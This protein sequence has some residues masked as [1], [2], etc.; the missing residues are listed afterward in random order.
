MTKEFLLMKDEYPQM[1]EL[2]QDIFNSLYKYNPTKLKDHEINYDY[3]LNANVMDAIMKSKQYKELRSLTRLDKLNSATGTKIL[4]T[5]AKDIIENIQE[6]SKKAMEAAQQ[7][8][9]TAKQLGGSGKSTKAQGG[10]QLTLTEA[11][12]RLRE[13]EKELKSKLMTPKEQRV[14]ARALTTVVSKTKESSDLITDWGLQQ[15]DS[16]TRV[17]YQ[18]Q[19]QL[20]K[21]LQE[22][23]KLRAIAAL[24]GRY[25]R[26]ILAQKHTKIKR[27]SD[28]LYDITLGNDL[29]KVIPSEAMKLKNPITRKVFIKQY[30]EKSLLQH[31]YEGKVKKHKGAIAIAIDESGSMDGDKEI[32]AKALALGLMEI[33][34]MQ[35]RNL[36]IV[37]FNA[38]DK[39]VLRVDTFL[40]TDPYDINKVI[41][42]ATYFASGSTRFSPA[43]DLCR[44]RINL[45]T[46]F[47]TADIILIT[48]GSSAVLP[49]WA[50][51]FNTWK[52][53]KKVNTYGV[54]ID[55][56]Y[57]T[58]T[59]IKDFIDDITRMSSFTSKEKDQFMFK[60]MNNL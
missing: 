10:E 24:M 37:H 11:I 15:S 4:S 39:E 20:I 29:G 22:N 6:R 1:Q 43:L 55:F 49:E 35:K 14:M 51:A 27:G 32:W 21:E 26:M 58:K 9:L 19:L 60:M 31:E 41:D 50:T 47:S 3:W 18:E 8:Y 54:I 52:K 30:Y 16:F 5:E 25:K 57:S 36:F 38:N 45:E 34:R 2:Q 53:E 44:D 40:K 7:A 48:D 12:E 59:A 28:S 33:A 46:E 17:G 56:G 13:A 23:P 42:C